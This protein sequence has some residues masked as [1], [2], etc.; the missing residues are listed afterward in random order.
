MQNTYR[1]HEKDTSIYPKILILNWQ[2][3]KGKRD[4]KY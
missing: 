4:M 1:V 2:E 3:I